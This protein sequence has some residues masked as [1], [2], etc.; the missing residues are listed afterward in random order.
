MASHSIDGTL[1]TEL[2]RELARV[3]GQLDELAQL[4]A[5]PSN[6]TAAR[7]QVLRAVDGAPAPAAQVARAMGLTRQAVQQTAD[8]LEAEGLIQ[9]RANPNH[10]RAKLIEA[11]ALGRQ[12]LAAVQARQIAWANRLGK[13]LGRASLEA[14]LGGI[15]TIGVELAKDR[16]RRAAAKP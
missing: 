10:R 12:R 5:E 4:L 9:Y 11:T 1:L 8:A 3:Q 16:A 7:W 15:R 13:R 14:S 2:T 6:L